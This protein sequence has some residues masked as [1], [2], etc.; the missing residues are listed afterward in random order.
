M[1]QICCLIVFH[2][3]VQFVNIVQISSECCVLG[4]YQCLTL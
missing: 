3:H 4:L 2:N 1:V